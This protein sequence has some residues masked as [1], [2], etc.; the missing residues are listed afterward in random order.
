MAGG[1]MRVQTRPVGTLGMA[2]QVETVDAHSTRAGSFTEG[3]QVG[4]QH[5]FLTPAGAAALDGL[6]QA[7]FE[8]RAQKDPGAI[9]RMLLGDFVG[10]KGE[11]HQ[12]SVR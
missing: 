11:Q 8:L 6:A 10:A 3:R 9:S 5:L 4:G 12:G 7:G 1:N 2:N